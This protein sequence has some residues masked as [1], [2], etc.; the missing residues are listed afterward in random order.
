LTFSASIGNHW[1]NVITRYREIELNEAVT[2]DIVKEIISRV[3]GT[4][5]QCLGTRPALLPV[6]IIDLAKDGFIGEH[7]I[8]LIKYCVI[9]LTVMITLLTSILVLI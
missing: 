8:S 9:M 7:R 1:D 5:F 4:V 6:H 3:K 2:P